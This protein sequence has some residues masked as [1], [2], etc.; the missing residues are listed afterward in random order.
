LK[1]DRVFERDDYRCAYCG[2]RFAVDELSVDH[3]EPH[4]RGGDQSSGNLVTAC[5]GC[6]TL[7]GHRRV[8]EFLRDDP[9]ARENFLRFAVHVWPRIRRVLLEELRR[10]S[11]ENR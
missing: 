7:K 6:N 9:T 2:Q 5:K 11:T 4:V 3:V 1:R 10:P 8:S